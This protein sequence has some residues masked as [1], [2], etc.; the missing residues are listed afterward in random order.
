[1]RVGWLRGTVIAAMLA[2]AAHALAAA[3]A[4]TLPGDRKAPVLI[5]A[6][7]MTYD[8]TLG[9]VVASGHVEVAQGGQTMVADNLTYNEK[10]K[11]VTASGNVSLVDP[12]GNVAFADYMELTDDLKEG[13]I[14]DIR[15]LLSDRSRI[16]ANS[17][18]RTGGN[19]TDF[20]KGVFSP[21][22]LCKS[23]PTRAPLWQIKA[24]KVTRDEVEQRINY[25]DAWMEIYGVPVAYMPFFSHPDPTAKRQSG[26]LQ[27]T[28]SLSSRLG[29]GA[30]L[31]FYWVTSES[32]DVTIAPIVYTNQIPVFAGEFRQRVTNGLIQIDGSATYSNAGRDT[33]NSDPAFRGA[34]FS[35]NHFD[36]DDN[37]RWGLEANRTTDK[38]YLRVY[39]LANDTVLTSRLFAEG[40]YGRSYVLAQA[41]SF[42]GLGNK[43]N[44]DHAPIVAPSLSFSYVSEP[45]RFG[46]YFTVNGN[47]M[48][49]SRIAGRE[50][51]RLSL[52]ADW[53]LPYTAP[54]GDVYTLTASLRGDAYWV[55][56]Q[57]PQDPTKVDPHGNTFSGFQG[58]FLPQI[59]GEWRYPF[60]R[61]HDSFDEILQPIV[62]FSAAP[63]W[64]N[65]NKIPNEDSIDIEF[66]DTNLFRRDRFTGL[67]KVDSGQR[68]SYGVEWSAIAKDGGYASF[69]LGQAYQFNGNNN[70]SSGTG[71]NRNLTAVVG[72]I[73]VSPNQYL[74]LLYTYAF[75]INERKLLRNEATLTAG[76][77]LLNGSVTYAFLNDDATGSG[78]S[79]RSEVYG[80]LRSQLTDYW[81]VL[82][83]ARADLINGRLLSYGGGVRY[84]DECFDATATLTRNNF[85]DNQ[86]NV[87][88]TVMVR[89]GFKYL[90][91]FGTK[92]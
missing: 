84:A 4:T 60:T 72:K 82:G 76:P 64:G 47:A 80:T 54:A 26:F 30:Q 70:F 73:D 45:S 68:V 69:F 2:T 44:N 88:T 36:I 85:K 92:F 65:P 14:R 1:M 35:T 29:F 89:F 91:A 58:R 79:K 61:H 5:S 18:V 49:L 3:P 31:P 21:C 27:P 37:W 77:R 75:D 56:G 67:D 20:S 25:N 83:T 41:L 13:V 59:S 90:G 7:Q 33:D 9:I 34:I 8:Q 62:S 11:V 71:L 50:S 22:E 55:I 66:D 39:N 32:S 40:F 17:A 78:F 16:A 51:R 6:D 15:V 42:Q 10:T 46:S 57:D 48:V 43:Y 52:E 63:N 74:D 86:A 38:N 28:L 87:G 23:D 53:T 19:R 24:R 12:S 81:S